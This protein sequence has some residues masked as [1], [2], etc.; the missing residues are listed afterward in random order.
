MVERKQRRLLRRLTRKEASCLVWSFAMVSCALSQQLRAGLSIATDGNSLAPV[1][2]DSAA[3]LDL[4]LNHA[5]LFD[6]KNHT[7]TTAAETPLASIADGQPQN[8]VMAPQETVTNISKAR[9]EAESSYADWQVNKHGVPF[10]SYQS[11][12]QNGT[13]T[14]N[15]QF[16]VQFVIAGFSKCGTSSLTSWLSS[17]PAIQM[18]GEERF[19]LIERDVPNLVQRMHRLYKNKAVAVAQHQGRYIQGYKQPKDVTFPQAIEALHRYFPQAKLIV[20][21]RHP[22]RWFESFWNFWRLDLRKKEPG[23]GDMIGRKVALGVIKKG[24]HTGLGEFHLYLSRLGKTNQTQDPDEWVLLK[25][26]YLAD[27]MHQAPAPYVPHKVFFLEMSQLADK[28]ESRSKLLRQD[29]QEFLGLQV[30]FPPIIHV[31]PMKKKI[32]AEMKK[33]LG[34][35]ICLA[36]HN[37]LRAELMHIARTASKWIRRYFLTSKDVTV[38]SRSFLEENLS[39]WMFDPCDN[40]TATFATKT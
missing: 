33:R 18:P 8:V 4:A 34:M 28:N 26:F 25:D 40:T 22:I 6:S 17:H 35:D 19:D 2:Q 13:V 38:S 32:G 14:G 23:D 7:S 10:P 37:E 9:Q 20:T 39:N 12:V 16:L 1:N 27:E 24:L 15:V 11:L 29:L 36:E 21:V 30:P 3:V 5:M 31:R